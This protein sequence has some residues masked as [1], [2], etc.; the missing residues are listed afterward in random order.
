MQFYLVDVFAEA[1][2]QG[3]QLAVFRNA[4]H[5]SPE[6]MQRIARE[7]NFA[8]SAF[9]LSDEP[10]ALGAFRVRIFTPESEVP[11]AGHPTLGAA[12]II[13]E[14]IAPGARESTTRLALKIGTIPVRADREDGVL[15]FSQRDPYFGPVFPLEEIASLLQLPVE[16][17]DEKFP[18]RV[19]STGLPYLLIPLRDLD[20][21]RSIRIDAAACREWLIK[22]RLHH[23][24]HPKG[25]TAGL[26]TFCSETTAPDRQLNTR[27]FSLENGR[28]VEDAATGSANACLAAYLLRQG[29]DETPLQ[30]RIEQGVEMGRPSLIY[31]SAN[32][33][34]TAYDIRIG[35]KVQWIA[36]GNWE[37]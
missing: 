33:R 12:W 17:F 4:G 20:A 23:T 31:L 26:F 6:G 35:G 2:C 3:N 32:R 37:G 9:I 14:K 13:R 27:M 34:G 18:V 21:Q 11:F 19:V 10:T 28:I 5:L 15:Y 8:E 25:L 7:I 29:P 24:N 22:H 1:P 30:L 16:A 36:E